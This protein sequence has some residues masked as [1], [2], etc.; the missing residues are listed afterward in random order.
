MLK[1]MT[2]MSDERNYKDEIIDAF[3]NNFTPVPAASA[4]MEDQA[5]RTM[6]SDE[7]VTTLGKTVSVDIDDIAEA[8]HSRGFELKLCPDGVMRWVMY[9][10]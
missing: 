6:S 1:E 9:M 2:T 8:A 5:I 4:N 3:F 10:I 7:I